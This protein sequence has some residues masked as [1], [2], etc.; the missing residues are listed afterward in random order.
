MTFFKDI[1]N[2]KPCLQLELD[3]HS[4]DAGVITRLEAFLES[5]KNC[6]GL[7]IESRKSKTG[8]RKSKIGNRKLYIPYMGDCSYGVAACFR[9]YGQPAEVMPLADEAT[10]LQGRQFT[11]GKECLPCAITTG[12]MLKVIRTEGIDPDKTAFFMPGSSGPCR[13]GMYSHL[14]RLILRYAGVEGASVVAPNQDDNFYEE[15]TENIDGA[16]TSRFLKDAWIATVGLDLLGK[17]ILRLRPFAADAGLAQR[18]YERSLKRWTQAVENRHSFSR[19]RQLM[20]SIA[21]DFAAVEL[22][23]KVRKP[24]IGIVGEIYVRNHPFANA[25]VIARL[26]ELG[27]A[28]ALASLAEWI[29][30]TNFTRGRMARRRWRVR[31][32]FTNIIQ[33]RLQHRLE[34]TLAKPLE[35]R[36]GKLAEEPIGHVLELAAPYMHA[37]FEGEAILS[38]GKMVE[39]H[40]Q[41]FGGVVN[42][43]PFSCMPSTVVSTQTRRVSADCGDMPILNLSF[44]GQEDSTL[45]TRLEAFVEQV[46]QRRTSGIEIPVLTV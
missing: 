12:D 25:N 20:E 30:Y 31:N 10:L 44:D 38:I 4:A 14:H 28:C 36:F 7:V 35:E 15:F 45:T 13:F 17:L 18:V 23:R 16:S 22:D 21:D 26:E 24:R 41:G 29:Y 3:E 43:M 32:F 37:S 8:S 42:V 27:A 33:N 40:H 5:L 9:A 39:Y 6:K 11:T 46:R 1:M 34:Q 19:M 2:K